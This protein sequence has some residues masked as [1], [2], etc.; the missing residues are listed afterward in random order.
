M[1][2]VG[3]EAFGLGEVYTGC[4]GIEGVSGL[5]PVGLHFWDW[6]SNNAIMVRTYTKSICCDMSPPGDLPSCSSGWI[7][8]HWLFQL[9]NYIPIQAVTFGILVST[10]T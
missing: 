1:Q 7:T 9:S 2:C 6:Y 3:L 8:T 10:E 4:L 5:G